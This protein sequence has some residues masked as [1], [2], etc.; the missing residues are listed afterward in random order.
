MKSLLP[1]LALTSLAVACGGDDAKSNDT[2]GTTDVANSTADTTSDGPG[3][4]V[5]PSTVKVYTSAEVCALVSQDIASTTL[6]VDIS[7]VEVSEM[8]TPQCS[9]NFTTDDG[10]FTNLTLAVQRPI[11]DLGG[12][13]GKAGYEFTIS[14]VLFDTPYEPIA[15]LGDEAAAS[16]SES[17]T[18]IAVLAGDQ[19]FTI[20]TT[21]PIDIANLI[22]F[23]NAV[24]DGFSAPS[25]EPTDAPSSDADTLAEAKVQAA[26]DSLPIDWTGT[27]ASDLGEEGES[28]EDI[29]FAA[30]L[31]PDEYNLDNLDL[32]SAASWE[33][34]AEGPP[35][36]SPFG[37]AQASV[38]AR[39]FAAEATAT[40]AY[41]VLERILGTDE[42]RECLANE[43]P[44]QLAADAPA[45]TTLEGRVEGTTIEGADVGARL[46]VTF[47]GGGL[48]G[49]FYVD[50]VAARYESTTTIF[51]VFISFAAPVD[52]L[53]ASAMF[54]AALAAA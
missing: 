50:F 48:A 37:G 19:V 40:D 23:G 4:V 1:I 41:A 2:T 52:Q 53:V 38:E 46:I 31:S 35:D 26:L 10:T 36:G 30:C 5:D 54:T 13:A 45:G 7:E 29:V 17:F 42:G 43:V 32:D 25:D 22:A 49:E 27:I 8:S 16:A 24:V 18:Q 20:A 39:V 6:G 21:A 12:A 15:G 9:Y 3:D 44:G 47:N 33:L 28:G 11:E 51:A 14:F 34:D